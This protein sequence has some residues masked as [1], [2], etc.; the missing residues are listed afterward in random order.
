VPARPS[1]EHAARTAAE[2]CRG[3]P[4][5]A[6]RRA[7]AGGTPWTR[8][9]DA[10][11]LVSEDAH[12]GRRTV[13]ARQQH[14][15]PMHGAGAAGPSAWPALRHGGASTVA[16]EAGRQ[17]DY[18]GSSLATGRGGSVRLG[19]LVDVDSRQP[20]ADG[21]RNSASGGGRRV[22]LDRPRRDWPVGQ[23]RFCAPLRCPNLK[24]TGVR[25]GN[26][27][28]AHH[29]TDSLPCTGPSSRPYRRLSV[30]RNAG[31]LAS[32]YRS[33]AAMAIALSGS[34][35]A[36]SYGRAAGGRVGAC[37]KF[38][39]PNRKADHASGDDQGRWLFTRRRPP[40]KSL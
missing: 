37:S 36:L 28:P 14:A 31:S 34:R 7:A 9:Q 29:G 25:I 2:R 15:S 39:L 5:V 33:A 35:P 17:P 38:G 24:L 6:G 13:P 32:G 1:S 10:R 21:F 20:C 23:W 12:R 18:I 40:S 30:P 22:G 26:E 4:T 19:Q 27:A 16:V 11:A 3:W 8:G